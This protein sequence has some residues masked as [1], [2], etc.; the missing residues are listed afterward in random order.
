MMPSFFHAGYRLV[1]GRLPTLIKADSFYG[2]FI[3]TS[4][5]IGWTI[6][7]LGVVAAVTRWRAAWPWIGLSL[8]C[9]VLAL[10]P[11]LRLFGR[12]T[13]TDFALPLMLPYAILDSLPGFEFMRVSGR[14]M[15]LARWVWRPPHASAWPGSR[16][17]RG[18]SA[19]WWWPA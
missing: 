10:G 15:M 11:S 13:F 12:T 8:A 7:V 16:N 14:F 5:T 18:D 4:V 2:I 17:A 6:V 9:I 19:V 1:D 3:E